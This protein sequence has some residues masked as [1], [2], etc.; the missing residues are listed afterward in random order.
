MNDVVC[1]TSDFH[2]THASAYCEQTV[3]IDPSPFLAPLAFQLEKGSKILDIGCGSGRDLLW[4]QERGYRPTGF[5]RSAGLAAYARRHSGC[6]VIEGDLFLFDFSV[7]QFDALLLIG[8]LVH[9]PDSEFPQTLARISRAVRGDGLIYLTLKEGPGCSQNEDGRIFTLWQPVN[10]EGIFADL[11]LM[12]VDFA[13]TGSAVNHKD[14][15]LGYLLKME[16]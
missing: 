4:L 7:F 12:I 8:A 9:V 6:P 15:W 3:G 10:L 13:R 1:M 16:G 14:I 11:G 5:E 2:E